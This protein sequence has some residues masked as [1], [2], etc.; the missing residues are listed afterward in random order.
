MEIQPSTSPKHDLNRSF[1]QF[2]SAFLERERERERERDVPASPNPFLQSSRFVTECLCRF[3]QFFSKEKP[4]HKEKEKH[5][6]SSMIMA[7]AAVRRGGSEAFF[8]GSQIQRC[9]MKIMGMILL[10]PTT[11][12]RN[13][14]NFISS[15]SSSSSSNSRDKHKNDDASSSFRY[16]NDA[17]AFF[18]SSSSISSRD[19]HQNDAS[20]FRN[21]DDALAYF[22]HML[23]RKPRPCIIQFNKLLSAIVKMRHY[24]DAVISLSKQMELAGLSPDTYTLHMLINCFFQLQRV[25]LGFSVLAKIIKL[26]L[27]LTIVTF[28]TLINGLCK[29][30]KFGQAVE[31]FDDMVARG[32]QPDV[33]TYTT[34]ING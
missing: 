16:I 1:P 25:D 18:S 5:R 11:S 26:G 19:K 29:V 28:N 32:Y 6:G 23:H 27:Q 7:A 13:H 4:D 3:V 24:H 31:L 8:I 20:S 12:S 9:Q 15:S 33:H 2:S 10:S 22:N 17:L 14:S 34:I 30:G 21:I